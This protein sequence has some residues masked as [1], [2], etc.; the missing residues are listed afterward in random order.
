MPPKKQ[1][2][3]YFK[4]NKQTEEKP[5][6]AIIEEKE[7]TVCILIY[8][9]KSQWVLFHMMILPQDYKDGNNHLMVKQHNLNPSILSSRRN[10]KLR[11]VTHHSIRYSM[12]SN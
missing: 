11:H 12:H 6:S 9:S 10:M 7:Y 3:Q 4:S 2:T 5:E 1:I 8:L